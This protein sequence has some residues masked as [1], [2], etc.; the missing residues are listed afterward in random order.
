MEP[1]REIVLSG[2]TCHC[3]HLV[4][5]ASVTDTARGVLAMT[6]QQIEASS[7]EKVRVGTG[8]TGES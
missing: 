2:E 4:T 6:D 7:P 8:E 1:L 3:G 5:A